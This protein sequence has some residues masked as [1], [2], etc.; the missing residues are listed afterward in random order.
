MTGH[1]SSDDIWL[2]AFAAF[3]DVGPLVNL[4]R[5]D[6]PMSLGVR[7]LL[8]EM[9]APGDPPIE[10]FQL[11]CKPNP[12][13]EKTLWKVDVE[14]RYRVNRAQGLKS[15]EAAKQTGDPKAGIRQVDSRQVFRVVRERTTQRLYPRLR[16]QDDKS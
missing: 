2:N 13:F 7:G 3:P 15:E 6:L 5:S 9:L 1:E 11:E 12:R 16:G 8:A 4:L 10:K 14:T